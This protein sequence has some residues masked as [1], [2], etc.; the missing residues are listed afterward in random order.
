MVC[1]ELTRHRRPIWGSVLRRRREQT[2]G[3]DDIDRGS[4]PAGCAAWRGR[5]P[6]GVTDR[7]GYAAICLC[8]LPPLT[9]ARGGCRCGPLRTPEPR[10]RTARDP[11]ALPASM[12]RHSARRDWDTLMQMRRAPDRQR[13]RPRRRII[14]LPLRAALRRSGF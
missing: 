7:H 3:A 12:R 11:F 13:T 1:V 6:S 2:F 14:S 9:D 10:H 8:V 5:T 4:G